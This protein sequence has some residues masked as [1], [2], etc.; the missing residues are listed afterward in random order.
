MEGQAG[1]LPKILQCGSIKHEKTILEFG[2][3]PWCYLLAAENMAAKI[4]ELVVKLEPS[5]VVIEETNRGKAR[6]TQKA[7]EFLHCT[8][9]VNLRNVVPLV[10]R[11]VVYISSSTWRSVLGISLSKQD[12][13]NNTKL[14]KAKRTAA[15]NGQKLDKGKL[16]IKG[17]VGKK[18][19]AIRYVNE[20]YGLGLKM[21]DNDVADSIALGLS[22]FKGAAVCDA[23]KD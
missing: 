3:Y 12:K 23:N 9:L 5:V 17:R 4:L 10:I 16:G 6:Y 14:S 11:K 2:E 18:H 19:M 8:N 15:A 20:Q 7:L 13:R 1:D 21:K 22:Y